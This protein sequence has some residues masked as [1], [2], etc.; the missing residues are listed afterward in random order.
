MNKIKN[1]IIALAAVFLAGTAFYTQ[2]N[3][4]AN[5]PG[6]AVV[7]P[8]TVEVV[9]TV[10]T[11]ETVD[12]Y[13]EYRFKN[14]DLLNEHYEKHGREMGFE[15]AKDYEIAASKV[16]NNPKALHKLEAEDGDDVYYLEETNEFV[17]VSTRGYIRTYFSPDSGIKYY[18]KQ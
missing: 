16:V 10:E 8:Q 6:S 11:G 12:N 4:D 15:S 1:S 2:Q 7:Q 13:E 18:E 9:E 17:I 3:T 14:F 5:V